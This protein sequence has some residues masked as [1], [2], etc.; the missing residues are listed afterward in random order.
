MI[1]PMRPFAPVNMN[2]RVP[3]A[4]VYRH[5]CHGKLAERPV[6]RHVS[7]T[8]ASPKVRTYALKNNPSPP[9]P[10]LLMLPLRRDE[11][12]L[13]DRDWLSVHSQAGAPCPDLRA[14]W[15]IGRTC[16]TA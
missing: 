16:Y 13:R 4:K 7:G 6:R 9:S 10:I 2:P 15:P 12:R 1:I 8:D 5:L 3:H 14:D 11:F